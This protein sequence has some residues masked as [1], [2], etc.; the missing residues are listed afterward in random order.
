MRTPHRFLVGD[1]LAA[2]FVAAD[3][4]EPRSLARSGE[5]ALGARPAWLAALA[6]QVVEVFA[7]PP[8]DR[9]R[10]LGRYIA[11]DARV[12]EA[13]SGDGAPRIRR[14]LVPRVEMGDARWP[15]PRIDTAGDL[16]AW[17]GLD[18]AHLAWMADARGLER[19]VADER[20]R[21]YAYRWVPKRSGGVRLLEAP[22]GRTKA[23]QRRI[24]REI[25]DQ[26]PAHDAAHGFRR[27]RSVW[28]QAAI[29]AGKRVVIRIDLADFFAS[30]AAP[31]VRAVF[32]AL[33]YADEVA[34]LLAA[35]CTNRA[36]PM[37]ADV[38]RR[39]LGSYPSAA[40]VQALRRAQA[41]ARTPHLPQ[42]APTS[43]ALANL[44]AFALD[45]RLSALARTAHATYSRYADD[46]VFSGEAELAR[47]ARRFE[48]YVAA[49]AA[50]CGFAVNFRKTRVMGR[51]G[52]QTV[53]GLVTNDR[54]RVARQDYDRLKAILTNCAR[55][56]PSTQNRDAHPDFRAHVLGLVSWT[57]TGDPARRA[58]LET[59]LARIDW[60][61]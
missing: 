38:E 25:L 1:A 12:R 49:I 28:T 53:G 29:H 13:C 11:R 32:R 10:A 39:A 37:P 59:L 56:G 9:L 41:L 20:L 48:A 5:R 31:R 4:W 57:S 58:R 60:T 61:V 26:V 47:S 6:K 7:A 16:A 36:P 18:V 22:K 42:G 40:D 23:I 33:G 50:D 45:V 54:P 15:T 35:L 55:H 51:A 43:P 27:G 34:M 21:H 14:W 44:C 46:L 24:L 19:L 8:R 52:R 3:E 30:V 2:A 17:L